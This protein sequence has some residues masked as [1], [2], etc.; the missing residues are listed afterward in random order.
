MVTL[1]AA[2]ITDNGV[3]TAGVPVP[4]GYKQTDAGL[5][6]KDWDVVDAGDIGAFRG[7]SGFPLVYQG[8][9]SGEYPFFKVSDMNNDGNETFMKTANNYISEATRRRL[10]ATLFPPQTIVFAKVGAAVFL[11]RKKLLARSSCLDNNMAG[12]ILSNN[13]VHPRYIHLFLLTFR[14]GSLAGC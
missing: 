1:N 9:L 13:R 8:A 12:Y 11:E 2:R 10:G 3:H 14:I 6:P 5:V 7:G 4:R